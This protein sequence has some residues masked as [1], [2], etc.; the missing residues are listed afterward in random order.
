MLV[1]TGSGVGGGSLTYANVLLEPGDELFNA[2]GWRDLGD[3]KAI[4]RPHYDTARRMLGVTTNPYLWPADH[5][6]QAIA[7][8]MGQG[9]TFRPAEVGVFF[10]APS[11][12]G[13]LVPDPYFGGEGP[14]R[15]GC[16]N[17]GG[18]MVG[19]RY[20]AKNT[21]VKN[22]LYFAERGGAQVVAEVEARDIRPLP[23]GQP[24]GARYE[25]VC[26][27]TTQPFYRPEQRVRA[28]HV[29]V[30]A[31]V[32]GTLGLLFRCREATGSL[33]QLSP[34]LGEGVRTNS[35]ALLGVTSR[36]RRIDYA[37]G[38][39]ISSVFRADVVTAIEPVRYPHRSSLIKL[40]AT[41]VI[42]VFVRLPARLR[43]VL[44]AALR[45]PLDTI[46]RVVLPDW[47]GRTTILLVMQTEDTLMRLRGGRGLFT[48]CR[49][50]LLAENDAVSGI[51]ARIEIGHRVA[52]DFAA[53]TDGI[54]QVA[55]NESL[56]NMPTT[57]HIL[58]GCAIAREAGQGVVDLNC[59]VFNYPGLYVVDGSIVPANP[60]V[61][62]SLTITALA[63]YAMSRI[64]PKAD[65]R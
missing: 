43:G 37:Q 54:R 49:R 2:P 59:E 65:A 23:P 60:G 44:L 22:Y 26:R 25:V 63:E 11:Q 3:W 27:S 29:I 61:N 16:T 6:L 40:L 46:R 17:C 41:P 20:N 58:G 47:A 52:D 53:R 28:R 36:S 33:P 38:I 51:Q 21:L 8:E 10:G 1:L 9:H 18:C 48:L 50:G 45:H 34:C 13:Q 62:P 4:L 19:C 64:P 14:P 39:A 7:G 35:E 5:T 24:D 32:L 57:A 55:F 42:R 31:G 56:L 12:E 15:A 30:S